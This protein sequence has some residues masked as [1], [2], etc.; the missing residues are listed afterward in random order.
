MFAEP[1]AINGTLGFACVTWRVLRL[2]LPSYVGHWHKTTIMLWSGY[3]LMNT[4]A[5]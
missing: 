2:P 3:I 4:R 1:E 5:P